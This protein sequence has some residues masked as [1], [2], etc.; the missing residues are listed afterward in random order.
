ME[1]LPKSMLFV[2]RQGPHQ[3]PQAREAFDILLMASSFANKI[4]L[5]FLSD[6][7]FQ[8]IKQQD[9]TLLAIQNFTSAYKALTLYDINNV[10]VAK[11]D[12]LARGLTEADLILATTLLDDIEISALIAQHDIILNY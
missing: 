1:N 6:G 11:D 10:Y 2:L 12:L 3:T 4:S 7:L 8:L 5:L 9:T